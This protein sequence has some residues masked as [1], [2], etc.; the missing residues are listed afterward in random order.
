MRRELS[1][2]V[3]GQIFLHA[4]MAGMR[5][6]PRGNFHAGPLGLFSAWGA[7]GA[8]TMS[9]FNSNGDKDTSQIPYGKS[10]GSTGRVLA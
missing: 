5:M 8:A 3:V 4:C 7:T 2:L 9:R 6:R 10:L 1:R